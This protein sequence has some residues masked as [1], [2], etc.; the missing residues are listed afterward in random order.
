[1]YIE[2]KLLLFLTLFYILLAFWFKFA[3]KIFLKISKKML[4]NYLSMCYV[5]AGPKSCIAFTKRIPFKKRKKRYDYNLKNRLDVEI[6]RDQT[7]R[8]TETDD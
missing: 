5:I 3:Q 4:T 1:M 8:R 7:Y 6:G 2:T